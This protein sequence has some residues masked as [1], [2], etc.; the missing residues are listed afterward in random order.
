[1]LNHFKELVIDSCKVDGVVLNRKT[2][3]SLRVM[4]ASEVMR[5]KGNKF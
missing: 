2:K 3:L 1:M 5:Q 4:L